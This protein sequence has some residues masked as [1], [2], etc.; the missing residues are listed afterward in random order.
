MNISFGT[1]APIRHLK[2]TTILSTGPVKN[3]FWVQQ[4]SQL[5][6]LSIVG[7]CQLQAIDILPELDP[8]KLA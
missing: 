8:I 7:N 5:M 6:V 4:Y 3:P 1:K 2:P